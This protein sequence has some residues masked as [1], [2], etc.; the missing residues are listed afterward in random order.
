[1][2]EYVY[3]FRPTSALLGEFHELQNREIYL[4]SLQALNDPLE[5]FREMSWHSDEI[6]WTNLIR[7]Y[8]LCLTQSVLC[9][10]I[11]GPSHELHE[12]EIPVFQTEDGLPS[13]IR[14][15]FHGACT[16][17]FQNGE[18]GALPALL[19]ARDSPVKRYQTP[20]VCSGPSIST[21]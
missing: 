12:H 19:A 11:C 21:P 9:A 5:G 1:M 20:L 10:I 4:S 3:R 16:K 14:S 15:L 7:H 8:L 2:E 17:F 18:V 13:L 6:V